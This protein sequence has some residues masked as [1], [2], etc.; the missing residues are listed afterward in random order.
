[1]M[2]IKDIK[3][4]LLAGVVC[5]SF[6]A[7]FS[8][9]E[10]ELDEV[11]DNRTE[12]DTPEKVRLLL[13][14]A[15]PQAV[16]G[17]LCELFGDNYVDDNVIKP[18]Q[19]RSPFR[20]FEAEAYAWKDVT[21]YSPGDD[22]TPYQIW[23]EYYFGIA[24]ANHAIAAMQNM[25]PNPAADPNLTHSWGEAHVLRAYLHFVLVNVFA[26]AYKDDTQSA[27]DIGIPY[28]TQPEDVVKIDYS[29]P[30]YRHSVKETYDL[31]EKDLLEGIN[32]IDDSK[33]KVPAY[34]MNRNAANAFAAR[35]YLYKRDY[36]KVITYANAALGTNA[37]SMLRKWGSI[38][39]AT[40]NSMLNSYFDEK[41]SCN[42]LLQ[43][44]LSLHDRMLSATRF[45]CNDGNKDYNVKSSKNAVYG[46]GPNWSDRLK[47]YEG[48]IY[49]YGEN[50][51]GSWLFRIYEYFE[52]RDKIAG[53]GLVHI[54]YTPFT[55]E[56]TLLCRAE[57]KLYL[58]DQAGAIDDLKTWTQSKMVDKD[59]TLADITKFYDNKKKDSPEAISKDDYLSELHPTDMSASFK[60]LTGADW[61]VLQCILHF[62][63]IETMFDG[64]RWFDIKRYGILV[65][66]VYRGPTDATPTVDELAW[67]D[68]R[69][70]I[71]I[72]NNVVASG[73][74]ATDRSQKMTT[75]SSSMM[76]PA[77][78]TG[79]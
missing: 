63:R 79:K 36:N 67:N 13:V 1:M 9:C 12:I 14:S 42:F 27:A 38:K 10:S 35:F 74:P 59:L 28:V 19:H 54:I 75:N 30:Q 34:H 31:I 20:D 77:L 16:P 7:T 70:V 73:Y 32:L 4:F 11:P 64:L 71:Q 49:R 61:S 8:S 60:D 23:E 72:P 58:G 46:S 17:M 6:A 55:A 18:G 39:T 50:D 57:A 45:A 48:K 52:Y 25:C 51:D 47:A 44:A 41:A 53:I 3:T 5:L 26:E 33:Y 65:R 22:D 62:R 69:R 24:T 66:H 43:S 40:I 76:K 68:K 15:Y 78:Y 56:E 21:N 2:K 29:T 37:S